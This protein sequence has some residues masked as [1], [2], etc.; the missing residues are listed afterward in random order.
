MSGGIGL[1]D[2]N[3]KE[4]CNDGMG[5]KHGEALECVNEAMGGYGGVIF[6][7][8]GDVIRVPKTFEK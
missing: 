1:S 3:D 4:L 5:Q 8:T 6:Y 2:G 7:V